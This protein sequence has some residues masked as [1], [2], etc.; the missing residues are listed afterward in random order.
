MNA[1]FPKRWRCLVAVALTLALAACATTP[2]TP[3]LEQRVNEYLQLVLAEDYAA[4]YEY[5]SPGM[6]SSVSSVAYQRNMLLR[7]VSWS[8]AEYIESECSE[9]P[10]NLRTPLLLKSYCGIAASKMRVQ[11]VK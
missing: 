1:L 10:Q 6:R 2:K 8:S 9:D 3:P 11:K 5:L 7:K 4:A